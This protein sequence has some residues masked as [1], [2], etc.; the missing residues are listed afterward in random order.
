MAGSSRFFGRPR[1]RFFST[2]DE[3]E[4][5][6]RDV[7][8]YQQAYGT[9][10]DWWFLDEDHRDGTGTVTDD[11][12]DEGFVES[13]KRYDGP[14]RIPVVSAVTVQG[15]ENGGDA[16]FAVTDEV[17]LRLSY[18]QARRAGLDIDIV[19]N[20][21]QR[22]HDRFAFRGR[23]FDVEAIQSSGHFDAANRDTMLNVRGRQL[24]F[25]ELYDSPDM[26]RYVLASTHPEHRRH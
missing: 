3:L 23:I 16:G 2:R 11:I 13:G 7:E 18:D 12:Y 24:R 26:Q 25:D 21:E 1:G 8:L 9:E 10:V 5:I 17:V 14:R 19:Q 20:R 22:L 15:Q 4:R 6:G